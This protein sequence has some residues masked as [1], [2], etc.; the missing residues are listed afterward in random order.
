LTDVDLQADAGDSLSFRLAA[1]GLTLRVSTDVT[2]KWE[3]GNVNMVVG[4]DHHSNIIVRI[5]MSVLKNN[6]F[7]TMGSKNLVLSW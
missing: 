1:R 5:C 3:H 6:T 4:N 2:E 7:I